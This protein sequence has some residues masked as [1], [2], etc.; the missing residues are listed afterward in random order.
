MERNAGDDDLREWSRDQQPDHFGNG[1]LYVYTQAATALVLLLA[2]G[3]AY[4]DLFGL[5]VATGLGY[6]NRAL[7]EGLSGVRGQTRRR[8]RLVV[9]RL[10]D[11]FAAPA[12]RAAGGSPIHDHPECVMTAYSTARHLAC[13]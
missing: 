3:T 13:G 12:L 7:L 6:E 8:R 4:N 1:P 2:A 9:V 11:V 10:F 5:N